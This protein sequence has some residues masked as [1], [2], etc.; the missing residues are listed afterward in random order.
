MRALRVISAAALFCAA[1]LV[2]AQQAPMKAADGT[3]TNA[4]GMTLYTFDKDAAGSGKSVCNGPCAT[5]WPPLMAGADA[6]AS[7]DYSIAMRDD[8]ARQ[9]AF[10]GKPLYLWAK[11]QKPGDKTGD[12]FNSV[13]H[14]A[15]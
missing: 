5:N 15:K 1:G 4:S 8:G 9:W 14:T 12:G 7:G 13:W 11:D 6:K 2:W 10:K 3:L